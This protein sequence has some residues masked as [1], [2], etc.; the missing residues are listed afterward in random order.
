M[1]QFYDILINYG[2]WGMFLAALLSGS[3]LPFSSEVV[4]LALLA[5]GVNPWGL[6][7]SASAGNILGGVTCYYIGRST[8][9]ERIQKLLHIKPHNM[10][11][12]RRLVE[13]WG[14]W[15]GFFCWI[16]VLGDA[17][18][19]TLGIMRSNAPLT[20][21]TMAIGKTIRYLAVLLPA[22]G[23]TSLLT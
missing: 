21:T 17:I 13:R 6:L 19:V 5:L 22:L 4:M 23:I 7:F 2:S 11:R 8:T 16:A 12:A 10:E 1:E 14:V 15:I 18:L 9:P 20:L 3:I